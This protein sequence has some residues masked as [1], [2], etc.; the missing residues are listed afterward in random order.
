MGKGGKPIGRAASRPKS[1]TASHPADFL[2]SEKPPSLKIIVL[3]LLALVALNLIIYTPSLHY[4]FLHYDD[5]AYVSE[6]VEV[7]QG[8]TRHG[9]L[10]AFNIGYSA[11]WHP[12]AW[13]SHMLDV[14]FYGMAAQRHHLTNILL[15]IANS[16]LLFWLLYRTTRAWRRSAVVALLFAVHPLHVESVAWIAERKDVLSTL[17][18]MLTLHTYVSY[19]RRPSLSRRLAILVIFSLGLMAKPMLVTLPFVLLLFDI[20]PLGRLSLK[21]GQR[22]VW[23]QL[24][25]E[26]IP[27]FAL[28]IISSIITVIAQGRGEAVQNF[29]MLPFSL[30]AANA[31]VS[32]VTYI[33]QMIWPINLAACY[34]YEPP[35][36]LSILIS[37]L[38]IAS[39]SALA[40]RYAKRCQ[41]LLVGWIWFLCTLLPVIG[42]I[43]VGAQ[44]RADRYTYVPLIG[45]FIIAAW[46]VPEIIKGGRYRNIGL[47]IATGILICTLTAWARNQVGYWEND[48]ILWE[49]TVQSSPQSYPARAN[50][51]TALVAR[52][53][54]AA[55]IDQYTEALRINPNSAETHNALGIVLSK[56]GLWSEA[57]FHSAEAIRIKPDL[58]DAHVNMGTALGYL[59]RREDAISEFRTAL[60]INPNS[61]ETHNGLGIVLFRKGLWSEAAFHYTEAIRIKPDFA[62]AHANMGTLLGT[63]GKSEDAIS[64]FL[65]AL[66]IDPQKTE[67]HYNLGFTLA[68]QG[69]MDEAVYQYNKALE[70]EPLCAEAHAELGNAML[71]KSEFSNAIEH[72]G[73]ALEIKPELVNTHIN[74]GVALMHQKR[75]KEAISHFNEVLRINPGNVE[76][77][78]NLDIALKNQ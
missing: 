23:L 27:L 13:F 59:G 26:K 11:N 74:L 68:K 16:L 1:E 63:Q 56:K 39:V 50:L 60:K 76:A 37:V 9:V 12:L 43:Q 42:L 31:A 62:E 25:L 29:E 55:A 3:V 69:K 22:R 57:A 77:K 40:I 15:H 71:L 36:V 49:H 45:L 46:G 75:F 34:S 2:S 8:F 35:S 47:G 73:K 52:G 51:G 38:I 65:T 6:N 70:I 7:S 44:S 72:Y 10:W 18:W 61:A 54:L 58:A 78:R 19:V 28:S 4:G 17:F 53:D 66:K 32:Y 33:A 5:P 48:F 41:Y 30:R 24:V 67:I 21:A 64:E 20:W 14:Q